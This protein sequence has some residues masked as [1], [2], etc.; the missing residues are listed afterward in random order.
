[1]EKVLTAKEP[2]A[3]LSAP[4][5]HDSDPGSIYLKQCETLK[6]YRRQKRLCRREPGLA[7][8]LR[9]AIRLSAIEC[10]YQFRT[11]R[12]NCSLEV[13][14]FFAR[15]ISS[16]FKE[17][18][19]LFA[20][21]SAGLTHSLARACS[22]GRME[23]CTCDES[24]DLQNREA[25]QWGG[26]GDN[27]K[28]SIKFLKHFLG[29]RKASKDLRAR[30]DMHNTNVGIKAGLKT[31]C[32]CHGVSGSCAVRTC[33]KQLS[34]FHETGHLLKLKYE[35]AVKVHSVT[36]DAT[37]ETELISPKR[38]SYTLK[39]HVPRTTDLVYIEDSPSFCRPSKY[40]P[41]TAGRTCSKETNC[42]SMCCGQGYNTQ[43]L[44]VTKAC[45]CQVQWCCYVECQQCSQREEIYTCKH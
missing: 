18:A 36:N 3:V 32:K 35:A 20:I 28:Y 11:E 31:T 41:G 4:I 39:N 24:P 10:Q 30:V 7:E 44:L 8:G 43:S 15:N 42:E 38:H 5:L 40:S 26:C 21:S 1:S 9:D 23:R 17:T 16:C 22:S 33:W 19:F 2:L 34:S 13:P 14:F 6:L 45:H 27:L 25:W 12:W 29:Q 37:G